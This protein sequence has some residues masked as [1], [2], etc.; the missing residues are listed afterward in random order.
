MAYYLFMSE[1]TESQPESCSFVGSIVL[2]CFIVGVVKLFFLLKAIV[3]PYLSRRHQ[4]RKRYGG[5][6][7]LVTGGSE[8]IGLSIAEELAKEG[9]DIILVSRSKD[10]LKAARER[11]QT[12]NPNIQIDT[13]SIDFEKLKTEEDYTSAFKGILEKDV[14]VLVNNVGYYALSMKSLIKITSVS[15]PSRRCGVR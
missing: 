6:W 7:A 3:G 9:F 2:F 5:G 8:G 12:I 15:C 13:N 10:K 1:L 4:L 14:S 11:L